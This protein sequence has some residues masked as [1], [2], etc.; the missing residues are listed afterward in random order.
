MID[1]IRESL[2]ANVSHEIRTPLNAIIGFAEGIA[3]ADSIETAQGYAKTIVTE[4]E[5]LLGILNQVLDY[6]KI[7]AG[8]MDIEHRPA[9]LAKLI[10]DISCTTRTLAQNKGLQFQ[11]SVDHDVPPYIKGDAIRLRQVL[12]NLIS[13]AIKFTQKGSITL[14]VAVQEM[15]ADNCIRFDVID[16]GIGITPEKQAIIFESFA[17]EDESATRKFG[18]IGLGISTSRKLVRLMHGHIGLESQPD[19]GSTFWFTVPCAEQDIPSEAEELSLMAENYN[20]EPDSVHQARILVVEDYAPNQDVVTMHL[21]NAGHIVDIAENGKE[22]VQACGKNSYDL[23]LMDVQMPEMNGIDATKIIRTGDSSCQN[24]PIIALTANAEGD[25]Q[26]SCLQVGMNDVIT[27]PIRRKTLINSINKWLGPCTDQVNQDQCL[28][29]SHADNGGDQS[30]NVTQKFILVAEDSELIQN[31]MRMRLSNAGYRVDIAENGRQAAEMC[32]KN[33]YDLVLMD[34]QMPE[35][36]GI[37]ATRRI[38]SG[39]AAYRDTPIIGLTA[40]VEGD[41]RQTCL[42]AGMNDV[43][44][45]AVR[46]KQLLAVLST[47]MNE[48]A[49]AEMPSSSNTQCPCHAPAA[50]KQEDV[51][52]DLEEAVREFGGDRELVVTVIGKFLDKAEAQVQV[53]NDALDQ[54]DRETLR[55]EAHK[56]RGGAANLTAVPLAQAAEKLE[57]IAPSGS[58]AE[59]VEQVAQLKQ[60]FDR[61]KQFM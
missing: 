54:Q 51:P 47:W 5:H 15:D 46:G 43:I 21:T 58:F 59:A 31:T 37:D 12:M 3:Q 8:Q 32:E 30:E 35:M 24:V 2:I 25:T 29:A 52:L 34:V 22:A 42:D 33:C 57:R 23:I 7:E 10:H 28:P 16:T 60:E 38:R 20:Y 13:N 55:Q 53:L 26:K 11:V 4:S 48:P 41:S 19:K 6:V 17:Q 39:H 45:K 36:N 14:N 50:G 1:S 49:Q 18:G 44:S 27:K 40:D 9:D 61:L 56:I